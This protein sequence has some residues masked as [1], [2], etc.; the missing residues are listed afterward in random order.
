MIDGQGDNLNSLPDPFVSSPRPYLA[1]GRRSFLTLAGMAVGGA[2]IGLGASSC[3]TAKTGNTPGNAGSKGRSG[4]SGD[5]LF[6]AAG[7]WGPPTN[8]NPFGPSPAWP[9]GAGRE[10]A[11][12]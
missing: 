2:V 8:F 11:D 10:P 9:T 12:L 6:V 5:T 7:Q 3:G 4:A 1:T